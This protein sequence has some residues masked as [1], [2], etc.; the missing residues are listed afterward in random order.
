[1]AFPKQ[2]D[3][4]WGLNHD[5]AANNMGAAGGRTKTQTNF[6]TLSDFISEFP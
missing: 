4:G 6:I 5:H 2:A 1:M 3:G